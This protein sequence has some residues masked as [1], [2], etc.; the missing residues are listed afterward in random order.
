MKHVEAC[1]FLIRCD[2][3]LIEKA[4]DFGCREEFL[5]MLRRAVTE[6]K[7]DPDKAWLWLYAG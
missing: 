5:D 7:D 3:A 1:E 4:I 2:G 6:A